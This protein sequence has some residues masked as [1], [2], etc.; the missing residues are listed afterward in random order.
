MEAPLEKPLLFLRSD[1]MNS[2]R[3]MDFISS[4]SVS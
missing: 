1:A 2:C 3:V 4:S